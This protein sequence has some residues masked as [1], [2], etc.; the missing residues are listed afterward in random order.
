MMMVSYI[1]GITEIGRAAWK[2]LQ[3]PVPEEV[4]NA[5]RLAAEL[6]VPHVVFY[7]PN[8]Y[9]DYERVPPVSTTTTTTTTTTAS[10]SSPMITSIVALKQTTTYAQRQAHLSSLKILKQKQKIEDFYRYIAVCHEVVPERLENGT[11]KL[12][13]PNPDDEALV[14]AAC[15]FGYSFE[16]RRDKICIVNDTF[17]QVLLEI[18]VLYTIPFTSS[19]KRM[20]VIIKD[21]DNKIKIIMKGQCNMTYPIL[22]IRL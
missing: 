19:R 3:R 22:L 2:L 16:D 1:Q 14:C 15:Y 9:Y 17:K 6:A 5:E 20:S 12:S 13:A 10:S 11:I 8:F 18:E 7:D 21:I 4:E